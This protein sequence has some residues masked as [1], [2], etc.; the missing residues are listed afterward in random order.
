MRT[1]KL[2]KR[3]DFVEANRD[4]IELGANIRLNPDINRVQLVEIPAPFRNNDTLPREPPPTFPTTIDLFVKTRVTNPRN[5]KEWTLFESVVQHAFDEDGV[6]L[7]FTQYR[8]GD[9]TNEFFWNGSAWVVN[10]V[11]WNTEA[12]VADNISDFPVTSLQLQV[13]VN[14]GTNDKTVTPFLQAIKVLY[15]SDIEFQEDLVYRSLVPDLRENI[16]P[17]TDF[18]VQ[19]GSDS[20]TIDLTNDFP[21]KTP[22][23][24]VDIDA[25]FNDDV[26]P[27]HLV[28]IFTSFNPVTKVITM[29]QV[30]SSGTIVA[31][32]IIY[33]PEVAVTTKR[34]YSEISKVPALVIADINVAESAESQGD[35]TVMNNNTGVGTRV[36]G[37]LQMDIEFVLRCLTDKARDQHRLADEVK[38][39]FRQNPL[40]RSRG[41]DEPYRLWLIDEFD[42]QGVIGQE[43]TES[44]RLRFRI[45]KALFYN[46]GD[47]QVFAVK[48]F[49]V[50][51]PPDLTVS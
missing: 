32:R 17:I 47:E 25:V 5:V 4:Q 48:R 49:V 12:D 50:Q 19:L 38:R 51:G 20:S 14:I 11:D 9:G 13:I 40:I 43:E 18:P 42:Q 6:Q 1:I 35:D 3:F 26:D 21:L 8:L 28:D 24:I 7:T 16:R 45:V 44:S 37:P 31:I 23:N 10:T 34:T 41:L 46:R 33:E 22:Y 30:I 2:I 36:R 15:K 39:H 29:N 27:N